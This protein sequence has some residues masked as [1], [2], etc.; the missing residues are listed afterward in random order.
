MRFSGGREFSYWESN[1]GNTLFV[2]IN[3]TYFVCGARMLDYYFELIANARSAE[4][5]IKTPQ[6]ILLII[7]F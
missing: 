2:I 3:F 1:V 7:S 4:R 6:S 5:D